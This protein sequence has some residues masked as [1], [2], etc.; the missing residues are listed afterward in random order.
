MKK[1]HKITTTFV[2]QSNR[3]L[4]FRIQWLLIDNNGWVE[5]VD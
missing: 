2:L 1:F 4:E 5:C 3:F